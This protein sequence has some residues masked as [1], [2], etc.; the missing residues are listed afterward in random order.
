MSFY[1]DDVVVYF[2]ILF[3]NIE[4]VEEF[5][6]FECLVLGAVEIFWLVGWIDDPRTKADYVI[7]QVVNREGDP[8]FEEAVRFASLIFFCQRPVKLNG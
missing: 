3:Y 4:S 2:D 8:M 5:G 7:H 1:D 6:F